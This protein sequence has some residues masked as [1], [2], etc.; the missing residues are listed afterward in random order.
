MK[1]ALIQP[2]FKAPDLCESPVITDVYSRIHSHF[3][4][5]YNPNL[6][7]LTI[8]AFI[9][10]DWDITYLHQPPGDVDYSERYDIVA[11]SCMT[12][13]AEAVY[14]ISKRF[15][16][17]GSHTVIGGIHAS[18]FPEEAGRYAD[19][20]FIGEAENTFPGFL[21]D[22]QSGQ[23]A[24]YYK[25]QIPVDLTQSPRPRFDL[26]PKR[27]PVYPIQTTRGCP[28]GCEFCAAS[29]YGNAYR[30]KEIDQVIDEIAYLKSLTFNPFIMFT[31]DN[32]FVNKSRSMELLEKLIP[33]NVQWQAITDVSLADKP[34]LLR[35]LYRAGC[36]EILLGFESLNAEHLRRME[37]KSWKS[38]RVKD[39]QSCIQKTQKA[40]ILVRGAFI[41]GFDNQTPE[42]FQW[43]KRFI[44][45]NKIMAQFSVL[46]PV[47]G[48]KLYSKYKKAG[49]LRKDKTWKHY[50]FLDCVFKHPTMTGE[51]LEQAA[52]DLFSFTYSAE[53]TAII[54]HDMIQ[55]E[56]RSPRHFARRR[57]SG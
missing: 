54:K 48:S 34:D 45:D 27:Y 41:L 52:A 22:F 23:P 8:S 29:L 32:L 19:T 37:S 3:L 38:R 12:R 47:P 1:I 4:R 20:V 28:H 44:R 40:G 14:E 33:L 57:A 56:K 7:L 11:L 26:L 51:E 42:E 16:R 30:Y 53:H 10:K 55:T 2:E 15:R 24:K 49:R 31:D 46:T 35:L 6:G 36:R 13:E 17:K 9:P 18:V 5:W 50:N 43:L 39:Y 21:N 25:S